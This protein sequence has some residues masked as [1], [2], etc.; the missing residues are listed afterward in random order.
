MSFGLLVVLLS[1]LALVV[2]T[3]VLSRY[4]G[5]HSLVI[6]L[7]LGLLLVLFLFS[8]YGFL[9]TYEL[10]QGLD[11]TLFHLFYGGLIASSITSMGFG[12]HSICRGR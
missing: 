9:A 5:Q 4:S 11:R 8:S 2:G 12:I 10:K 7:R 6:G 1:F 3:L